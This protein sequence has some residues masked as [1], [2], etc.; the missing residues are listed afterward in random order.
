MLLLDNFVHSDL[1]PGNIMV[2]FYKPSTSFILQNI[3]ASITGAAPPNDPL[4]SS[5]DASDSSDAIVARL[6]PLKRSKKEWL[7]E[8]DKLFDEGYQPELVL[9]DAGLVTQLDG[10]NRQNF[11]DLFQAIAEFDVGPLP[12]LTSHVY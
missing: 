2:K 3:W 6:R 5:Q 8:M 10:Q 9:L 4:V 1:H 11:L 7:T 12:L